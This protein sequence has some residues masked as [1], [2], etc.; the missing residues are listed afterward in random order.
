VVGLVIKAPLA[1]HNVGT[2][3]LDLLNHISE[4]VLFHLLELLV[5][6]GVLDLDTVLGLGLWGLEGAGQ[7]AN[8]GVLDFLSHGGMGEVLVDDDTL[9][10]LGVLNG[11][12]GLGDDLDQ[13]EVDILTVK[14]G[15]VEHRLDSEVCE[16]ILALADDLGAE[17]SGGALA[18]V[19]EVILLDVDG[20][21]DLLN[22]LDS[23]FTSLLETISDLEGVDAL[24]E[25]FLSL[26]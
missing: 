23:N 7:D 12:T 8:L 26:F 16:V 9:D 1:E 24:V 11:T 25:E 4:V 5:V 2:G 17:S 20:L 15:N 21:G 14:V 13:I 6:L 18:E 3:V 10:E 22:L 19:A